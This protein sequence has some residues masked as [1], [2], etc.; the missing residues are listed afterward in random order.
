M[1]RVS[2][3]AEC[4]C[5]CASCSEGA[6]RVHAIATTWIPDPMSCARPSS[7]APHDQS[8]LALTVTI[9]ADGARCF[10]HATTSPR[11]H[12]CANALRRR[13]T[14]R[15]VAST[16]CETNRRP[17]QSCASARCASRNG[18]CKSQQPGVMAVMTPRL[19]RL[20]TRFGLLEYS[21]QP[22]G[23]RSALATRV[24]RYRCRPTGPR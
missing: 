4:S 2:T 23:E 7:V 10:S 6:P 15:A 11:E 14:R 16:N 5:G 12:P 17:L 3:P 22:V 19:A 24:C 1:S 8:S 20:R 9:G 13:D 21:E 18:R